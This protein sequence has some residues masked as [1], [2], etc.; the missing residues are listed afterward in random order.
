MQPLTAAPRDHLTADQVIWLIRDSAHTI[1]D[2]G[3]E[4]LDRSFMVVEDI[5]KDLVVEGCEVSRQ[6]FADIHA[7]AQ[8]SL[9]RELSWGRAIV[10]PYVVLSNG[11]YDARFN[12]GAYYTSV[13]TV[14]VGPDTI[15]YDV[16]GIDVIHR[17]HD[18]I[19]SSYFVPTGTPVLA[20]VEEILVAQGF[21]NAVIDQS[22]ASVVSL[23][24]RVWPME[25]STTW[26]K[27]VNNL[28]SS[29]GYAGIWTDWNG[30]P[31]C[32]QYT[33]S[34]DRASEWTYEAAGVRSMVS[35]NRAVELDFYEVPNKWVAVRSNNVDGPQPV[36]GDGKYTYVNEFSGP[37]S[38]EARDGRVITR[39][40]SIE[41]ADQPSLVAQAHVSIEADI[42]VE[43]RFGLESSPNPLH[44]HFDRLTFNDAKVGVPAEVLAYDWRL[45]LDG[46][47]MSHTWKAV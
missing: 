2:A 43:R 26:L 1:I 34:G 44:W 9:S 30:A 32:E 7:A 19:G 31:R 22:K 37:T 14:D 8:F 40:L 27:V 15:I 33:V 20:K 13:P 42:R 17:L 6:S 45:P 46:G 10:R 47:L 39:V 23:G 11:D 4:L 16:E 35:E 21:T 12:L 3:M 18:P 5:S 28:L 29:V 24:D 25:D 41:A 36:E 38:V